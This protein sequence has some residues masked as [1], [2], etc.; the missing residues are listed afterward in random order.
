[1]GSLLMMLTLVCPP[2]MDSLSP[3]HWTSTALPLTAGSISK[4]LHMFLSG[5]LQLLYLPGS[6]A[7]GCTSRIL[8]FPSESLVTTL[9]CL[10]KVCRRIG[11]PSTPISNASLRTFVLGRS[12]FRA[13]ACSPIPSSWVGF[14]TSVVFHLPLAHSSSKSLVL[15]GI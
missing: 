9:F 3:L 11:M 5:Q 4:N 13:D 7:S 12:P 14:G 8:L 2:L 6:L 15:A 1:M 10:Q